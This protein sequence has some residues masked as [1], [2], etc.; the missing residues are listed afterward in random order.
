MLY[1]PEIYWDFCRPEV[2][3]QER[4]YGIPISDMDALRESGANIQL[5]AENGVEIFFTQ[6]FRHNFFMPICTRAIFL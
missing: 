6:V 5:L 3:V 4:N 2:L 1:V